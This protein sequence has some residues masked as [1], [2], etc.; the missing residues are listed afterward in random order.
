MELTTVHSN[1]TDNPA[2]REAVI[3]LA[4]CMKAFPQVEYKL[5]HHFAPGVYSREVTMPAGCLVVGKIHKSAHMNILIKGEITVISESGTER[6]VAPCTFTAPAFSRKAAYTHTEVVWAN[7][8][9]TDETDP[10]KIADEITCAS[11]DDLEFL[12][13]ATKTLR[14]KE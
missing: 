9:P 11:Y 3:S 1:T 7:I 2:Y 10:D 12:E 14:L 5:S 4:E 8:I 6:L 13:Y